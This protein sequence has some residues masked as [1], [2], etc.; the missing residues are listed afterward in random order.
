MNV[1]SESDLIE[2][3]FPGIRHTGEVDGTIL[4]TRNNIVDAIN[5]Q[6]SDIFPGDEMVANSADELALEDQA[7]IPVEYLNAQTPSGMPPH[8]LRLKEGMPVMLLRNLDLHAKLCDG[9]RMTVKKVIGNV[10]LASY[11]GG[12]VL[13]PRIPLPPK[14]R[15]YPFR[16]TRW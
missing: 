9:T 16:W 15:E 5:A 14:D 8:V 1:K 13:I 10:L 11:E 12:E 7:S 2:W 3:V 6:V 4:C